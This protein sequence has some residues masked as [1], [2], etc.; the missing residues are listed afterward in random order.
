M[1]TLL[2]HNSNYT[3]VGDSSRSEDSA[4]PKS[5]PPLLLRTVLFLMLQGTILVSSYALAQGLDPDKCYEVA[6]SQP[7]IWVT[8]MVWNGENLLSVD[9]YSQD[10]VQISTDGTVTVLDE[11][12]IAAPSQ[13]RNR[14]QTYLVQDED[15]NRFFS[16]SQGLNKSR[17]GTES[18]SAHTYD[19]QA[20]VGAIFDWTPLATGAYFAFGDLRKS[21][22]TWEMGFFSFEPNGGSLEIYK[23]YEIGNPIRNFYLLNVKYISPEINGKIYFLLLDDERPRI[24]EADTDSAEVRE[25]NLPEGVR[26]VPA[27]I[28]AKGRRGAQ[29]AT[30]FY[31]KVESSTAPLGLFGKDDELF[32]LSKEP[33][34]YSGNK[35]RFWLLNIDPRNGAVKS[36]NLIPLGPATA[37]VTV[38]AG[39]HWAF[40]R[41]GPVEALGEVGAPFMATTSLLFYPHSWLVNSTQ[42]PLGVQLRESPCVQ[43]AN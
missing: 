3:H 8:S 13:I 32:V 30:A 39:E 7:L 27:L 6:L 17:V 12:G 16:F 35:G 4:F 22:G 19:S 40:L 26:T 24:G 21:D 9:S 14:K 37:H 2:G 11:P 10:I 36:S 33:Y 1:P 42:I 15:T 34:D 5:L 28:G 38:A 20:E 43:I 23:R 41:K 18:I 31:R 25:I 29:N